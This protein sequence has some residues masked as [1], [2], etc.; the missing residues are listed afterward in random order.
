M[1]QRQDYIK[2]LITRQNTKRDE[3]MGGG[4][5]FMV[6][7]WW[8]CCGVH[9]STTLLSLYLSHTSC[10][11]LCHPSHLPHPQS[12]PHPFH[13]NLYHPPI[14]STYN[15]PYALF[16]SLKHF[17]KHLMCNTFLDLKTLSRY[18]L[19]PDP[20]SYPIYNIHTRIYNIH[21]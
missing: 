17:A 15:H 21:S 12:M 14:F 6:V 5:T 3:R 1:S 13:F 20:I 18:H 16:I 11:I 9:L 19:F 4:D 8:S 7:Y 10:I 2:L